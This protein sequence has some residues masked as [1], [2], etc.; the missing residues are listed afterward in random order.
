VTGDT[1]RE[2]PDETVGRVAA[3]LGMDRPA[4]SL[5]ELASVAWQARAEAAEAKLLVLESA[6]TWGTSCTRCA[7]ILDS[8]YAETVRRE[9][10]EA[11]LAAISARCR[12]R[13]DGPGRYGLTMAAAQFIL[14]LTEGSSEEASDA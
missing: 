12:E 7:G 5:G 9:K 3:M 1:P 11:K 8:A 4:P 10:A 2:S 6:V 13:I 14:G